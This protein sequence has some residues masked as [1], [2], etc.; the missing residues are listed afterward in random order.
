MTASTASVAPP[1]PPS[2]AGWCDFAGALLAIVFV[3][4]EPRRMAL[5]AWNVFGVLDLL[6]AVG[7][8]TVVTLQGTTPGVA[9]ILT[10]PLNLVPTF[11]VPLLFANHVL[12]FRR[13]VG[14]GR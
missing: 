13:L 9:P 5:H 1:P 11:F 6:V 7:T 8:A 12:I 14:S 10:F 4:A 2:R 3:L